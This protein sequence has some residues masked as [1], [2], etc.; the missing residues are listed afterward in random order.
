MALIENLDKGNWREFLGSMFD[1]TLDV[2]K[3]DRF[4]SVGSSVDDLRAWLA[5]GGIRRVKE[6]L[7]DQMKQRRYPEDKQA[8]ILAFVDQLAEEHR[9][10]LIELAARGIIPEA[11]RDWLAAC[12]I[13]QAWLDDWVARVRAGERPFDDW[14]YAHG[15][16]YEDI[17]EVYSVIDDF[18]VRHGILS[19]P[20]PLPP[21]R[22]A[23]ARPAPRMDSGRNGH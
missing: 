18:L 22:N 1:Y 8:D 17:V 19:A 12:G 23:T 7:A 20:P 5:R 2:L 9:P 14:M 15:H 21:R 16:S 3:N 11:S 4:R 10:R 6:H 13:T